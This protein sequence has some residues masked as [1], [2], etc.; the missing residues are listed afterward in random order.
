[1]VA[2]VRW[3]GIAAGVI[4]FFAILMTVSI[5]LGERWRGEIT[6]GDGK[7]L[8]IHCYQYDKGGGGRLM[9]Y[10]DDDINRVSVRCNV[11]RP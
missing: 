8:T 10:R 11:G 5:T 4:V 3:V 2:I 1:M 6:L 7:S 9:V